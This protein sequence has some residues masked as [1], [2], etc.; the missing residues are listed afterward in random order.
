MPATETPHGDS[1]I[2][3][4]G[5]IISR[6]TSNGDEVMVIRRKR[7]ADWTFPKGKLKQGESFAQAAIREVLEETGC[8]VRLG[9]FLGAVGYEVNEV[10]K[11]VLYWRMSVV[12]QYE[13]QEQEEVA[14]AIWVPIREAMEKL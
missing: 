6:A 12:K 8:R 4:A 7:H 11:V 9:K 3:A 14:E 10:P 1:V 13:L 5:G 2:F